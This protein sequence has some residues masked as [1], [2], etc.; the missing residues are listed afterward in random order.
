MTDDIVNIEINGKPV[1]A[2]KGQMLIEVTDRL[3]EYVPRF[4]Y[5]EKLSIAANCRMCLVEVENAPKPMPACATPVGE[6]M[7][8]F[9]KS[10]KAIAA[11]KATMEFLLINHPLDCPICDQGG[12]CELQ[13][14][15][16][17]YGRDVS[18]YNDGKRVVKDK[19]IGPLVSTDM[20]RCIHCT[21]CVRFGEEIQ[22]NPQLGTIDR[23]ED[24]KISTYVEQGIDH[25]LS[26]NIIDICPVGALNNKPYRYSA[27]AWE[28]EQRAMVSP[29]DCVGSNL[30]AHVL[31]GTVKRVV[32]RENESIN[33]SWISDRDRFSYEAIY[34]S[35]RLAAPRIKVGG[36]WQ[37]IDW[38]G[39]LS[40]TADALRAAD[41]D[42][43][44]LIA[45]S[46]ATLEECHLLVQLAAHLGT[47]N[48]D[49]RIGRRDVSDQV[50]DPLY[51]GFGCD[52]AAIEK[53]GAILVAG[54]N[55]RNEAPIIAH[56]LR[57][58]ALAGARIS[59][60]TSQEN[61]YFFDVADYLHGNGLVEML[62]G[63]VIAAAGR[64]KLPAS[65]AK[66]CIGTKAGDTH[67]RIAA[68][69]K[70]SDESLVLLG[71]I[72][73]RHAAY[74][75][76]RAL[77]AAIADLTGAKLGNITDGPNSAGAHLA[78]VLPHRDRG[79]KERTETGL[80]VAAM[81]DA[82]LDVIVLVNIEPDA[83]IHATTN[84][85]AKLARQ[86]FVV[87][88]TPFVSESLLEAADLLLPM[89]TF[90]ETSGTYVNAAGTWQ[91]FAGVANPV[92]EARPCWKV[93]RVLGNLIDAPSFDYVTSEDVLDEFRAQLGNFE[94]NTI[95]E[96]P[97]EIAKANGEDA[98]GDEI[99]TPLY[100][101]DALV[102]RAP[103]LQ[104]TAAAKRA[105][106][107]GDA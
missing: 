17:G 92:G 76:V 6:G 37:D 62:A 100:S 36:E 9:T 2:R 26:A 81:L 38:D 72:A 61:E 86:K 24:M 33:E 107:H 3:G 11:Q 31:R 71:C 83:D 30:Y 75:A 14:L 63:I 16:M 44:G 84:A 47:N 8:V 80:A 19:D 68:S 4:C 41:A 51:F 67:K 66:L 103:A 53:Q 22:G 43:I 101:V 52:I 65:V 50:N 95:R 56:R 10:A 23:A 57:K 74:S 32:P 42:K 89:G 35:D 34:S 13:D 5:H 97:A 77:A 1:E 28:M 60:A 85:V 25:E 7:K 64:K 27:R 46:A 45:S 12:E 48:I 102:R 99:D 49:H 78:G 59:F 98:P 87:A 96:T 93:L 69:L 106:A 54:S 58:A 40:K 29:H 90:A 73:G 91:S 104:R 82:S 20:T 105:A 79:G 55:I 18:R 94:L 39:A 15:A 21:R 88:I 70:D